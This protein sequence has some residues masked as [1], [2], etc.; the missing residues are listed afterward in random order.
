VFEWGN[1]VLS[2]SLPCDLLIID[3]LGPLEVL[4]NRGWSNALSVLDAGDYAAALVVCRPG[5]LDRL[6]ERLGNS[7]GEI[8]EVDPQNRDTLATVILQRLLRVMGRSFPA[9]PGD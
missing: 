5:L 8:H 9:A 4:G 7:K 2:R 1:E 3:E 6:Q